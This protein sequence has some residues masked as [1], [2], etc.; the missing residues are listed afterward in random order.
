M[1]VRSSSLRY[2]LQ[3]HSP[4]RTSPYILQNTKGSSTPASTIREAG[5]RRKTARMTRMTTSRKHIL[6]T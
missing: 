4:L 1:P 2:T 3:V 5:E 6:N